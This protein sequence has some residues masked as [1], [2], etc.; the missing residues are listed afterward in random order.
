MQ[1]PKIEI[2][3][4]ILIAARAEFLAHGF[5]NASIRM[6]ALNAGTSKS[7]I[8]NYFS[9][10]DALFC[11][12]VAPGLTAFEALIGNIGHDVQHFNTTDSI[13]VYKDMIEQ[14]IILC[15]EHWDSFSLLFFKAA[16]SSLDGFK[17][18]LTQKIAEIATSWVTTLWPGK[19]VSSMFYRASA[20]FCVSALEQLFGD[21]TA[22]NVEQYMDEFIKFL[23]GGWYALLNDNNAS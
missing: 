9:N 2:E 17:N 11:A 13:D 1:T 16:G 21:R 23:V 20:G 12:V 10:K 14:F 6:I 3:K 4:S 15:F 7:N 19:S 5:E 8:Y 18:M 22:Q